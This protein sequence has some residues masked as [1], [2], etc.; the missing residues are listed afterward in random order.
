MS[1]YFHIKRFV[2]LFVYITVSFGGVQH[3][4]NQFV[5][6]LPEVP[7]HR[8]CRACGPPRNLTD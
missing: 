6:K 2:L 7:L 3:L 4:L 5:A 1:I 8:R